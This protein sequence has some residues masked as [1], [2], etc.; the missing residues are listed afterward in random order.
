MIINTS[1]LTSKHQVTV[2]KKIREILGIGYKDSV[3]FVV[4]SNKVHLE[5]SDSFF[6]LKG[7]ITSTK[8]VSKSHHR[9]ATKKHLAIR[10]AKKN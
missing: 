10:H 7:S 1:T 3:A 4:K 8:S 2:P 9:A 6:D 5:P